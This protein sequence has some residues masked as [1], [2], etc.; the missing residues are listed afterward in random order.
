MPDLGPT[1]VGCSD[2]AEEAFDARVYLRWKRTSS[3]D[4]EQYSASLALCK[5]KVPPLDGLTVPRGELTGLCLQSRLVLVVAIALQRLDVKPVSAILLCDSQ[6]S[7]NAVDTRR[8][9]KP[10]F[11]HRVSEIKENMAQIR[12]YCPTEEILYVE[13]KLNPS[14]LSTRADC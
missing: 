7:I 13:S 12:K 9:L 8:K 6:C 5:S 1:I 3:C 14:D 11:Q 2:F 4:S 10:Y